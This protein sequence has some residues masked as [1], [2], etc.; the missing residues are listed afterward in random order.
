M[1]GVA[2][3]PV[4]SNLPTQIPFF[5]LPPNVKAGCV[6]HCPFAVPV[7]LV[8]DLFSNE[9]LICCGEISDDSILNS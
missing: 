2:A 9:T 1:V 6:N 7:D 4:V 5:S 8:V 3:V